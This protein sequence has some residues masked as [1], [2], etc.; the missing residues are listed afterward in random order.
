METSFN[1]IFLTK[2]RKIRLVGQVVWMEKVKLSLC[3]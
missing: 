3:F 1:H 2:S